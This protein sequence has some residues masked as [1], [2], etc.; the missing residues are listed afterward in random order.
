MEMEKT[1]FSRDDLAK[2]WGFHRNTIENFE[3]SGFLKRV[4]NTGDS[5][6]YSLAN[7]REFEQFEN[8]NITLEMLREKEEKMK[9]TKIKLNELSARM[10]SLI[11]E[12]KMLKDDL[13]TN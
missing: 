1:L 9:L 2:R 7:V 13:E 8:K 3:K 6:R 4:P 10:E 12:V 5:V 11:F